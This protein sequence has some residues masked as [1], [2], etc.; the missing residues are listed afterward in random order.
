MNV[1]FPASKKLI[2]TLAHD[3]STKVDI[4]PNALKMRMLSAKDERIVK[5]SF[6]FAYTLNVVF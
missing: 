5:V 2:V 6:E 3:P 1:W 4:L